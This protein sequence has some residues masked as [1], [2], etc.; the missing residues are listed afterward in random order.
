MGVDYS[1]FSTPVSEPDD[2]RGIPYPRIGYMGHLKKMLDWPLLLDLS[3]LHP[4]WSFVFVGPKGPH[5]EI[6]E[7]LE[8]MS[9]LA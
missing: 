2:L 8:K 9:R 5:P 3:T 6:D 4:E 1:K 7:M